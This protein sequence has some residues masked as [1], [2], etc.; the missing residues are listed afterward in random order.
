MGAVY[1]DHDRRCEEATAGL[2]RIL[3]RFLPHRDRDYHQKMVDGTGPLG[4]PSDRARELERKF[5]FEKN[6]IRG[7]RSDARLLD[8]IRLKRLLRR[9]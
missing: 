1:V 8:K 3:G 9:P 5:C 7:I 6:G 2:G 4:N